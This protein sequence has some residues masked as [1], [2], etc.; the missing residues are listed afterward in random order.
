MQKFSIKYLRPGMR[1]TRPIYHSTGQLLLKRG[2]ILTEKYIERLQRLYIPAVYVCREQQNQPLTFNRQACGDVIDEEI[3]QEALTNVS[4]IFTN[5]KATESLNIQQITD[6]TSMILDSVLKNQDNLIQAAD[7]RSYDDY[8][9]SH[10]VNVCIMSSMLGILLG[11]NEMQLRELALGTLMHDIGKMKITLEILNKKGKL[12][13]EEFAL[14]KYHPVYGY[15]ILRAC[16]SY[17][18][19]VCKIAL[20]HHEKFSG[21]GYPQGIVGDRIS[22]YA[23]I[24]AIADVYDALTAERAYK[25]AF[26]AHRAY[27]IMCDDVNHFDRALLQLFFSHVAIYPVG[28]TVQ[29]SDGTYGVIVDIEQNCVTSPIV[30]VIANVERIPTSASVFMK[31]EHAR[32]DIDFYVLNEDE[33]MDLLDVLSYNDHITK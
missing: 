32:H 19:K 16:G 13:D 30:Q 26:P 12:N 25:K 4:A 28:T 15:N 24:A 18:L 1:V 23:R 6:T 29:M 11:Y 9:F 33:V 21:G 17:S 14:I 5:Y 27:Q 22:E 10:S 2:T 20:Q 3:R 31:L 8:T 7:I